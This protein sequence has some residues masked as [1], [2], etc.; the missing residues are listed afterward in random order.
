MPLLRDLATDGTPM[1]PYLLQ[2]ANNPVD[3]Y[4]WGD[5]AFDK[6]KAE[7]K[8][9][10]VS[11]G[12]SACHWCHVMEHESFEDEETAAYMNEHFVCIKVDREEHPDVDHMY[13]DA[14][15]AIGGSGG[16][17]LNVFVTPERAP[18]YGGTYY[19][20]RPAYNRPSWMQLLRRMEEIWRQQHDEVTLQAGQ[21]INHLQQA[22]QKVY[23]NNETVI[24]KDT[25]RK[26]ADNL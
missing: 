6:A 3:W 21:L 20:P 9:V 11:I 23:E 5:D 2:H 18:F 22:S 25:C 1:S 14:V 19:P 15:Q 8:P 26:I 7:H 16:W 17:P 4:A 10:I 12:Y 13:M 24:D